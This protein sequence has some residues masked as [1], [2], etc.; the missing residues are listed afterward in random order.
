VVAG[1]LGEGL[2]YE[3]DGEEEPTAVEGLAGIQGVGE[4][5]G[6]LRH[7]SGCFQGNAR[8]LSIAPM[9]MWGELLGGVLG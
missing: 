5:N 8:E 7:S 3:G 1:A 6:K 4:Y 2:A 9:W